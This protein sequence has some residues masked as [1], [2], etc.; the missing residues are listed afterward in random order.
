MLSPWI[1]NEGSEKDVDLIRNEQFGNNRMQTPQNVFIR[2]DLN[3]YPSMNTEYSDFLENFLTE[4]ESKKKDKN[5]TSNKRNSDCKVR[6]RSNLGSKLK[7]LPIKIKKTLIKK[8]TEDRNIFSQNSLTKNN[9]K[10]IDDVQSNTKQQE[11]INDSQNLDRIILYNDIEKNA[12]L[13]KINKENFPVK[14]QV[15]NYDI[16]VKKQTRKNSKDKLQ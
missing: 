9:D 11:N 16:L 1:G 5:T 10:T 3:K 4:Q 8:Q 12:C 14:L 2:C 7:S 6:D 15:K 13:K